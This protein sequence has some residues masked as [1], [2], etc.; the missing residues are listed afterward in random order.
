MITITDALLVARRDDKDHIRLGPRITDAEHNTAW[1]NE[2]TPTTAAGQ[3]TR[4]ARGSGA[5]SHRLRPCNP[6][7]SLFENLIVRQ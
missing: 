2:T 1:L 7:P 4:I 3:T 5:E 6:S